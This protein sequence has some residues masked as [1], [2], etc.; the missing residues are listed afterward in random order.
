MPASS[1]PGLHKPVLHASRK[2]KTE[3][4]RFL[5][6]ITIALL[7][8]VACY[9]MIRVN[10]GR[11]AP[12]LRTYK[13]MKKYFRMEPYPME[14][15]YEKTQLSGKR[16]IVEQNRV[17]VATREKFRLYKGNFWNFSQLP[18]F[19]PKY[20][21]FETWPISRKPLPVDQK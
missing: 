20:G 1:G 14:K 2:G 21:N 18:S 7:N 11:E 10:L 13:I 5:S 9:Q 12:K 6:E 17:K 4:H 19:M 3:Q 16:A 8:I 15:P